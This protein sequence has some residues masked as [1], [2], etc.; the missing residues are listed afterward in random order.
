MRFIARTI[1]TIVGFFGAPFIYLIL[2]GSQRARVVVRCGDEV[3]LVRA[4]LAGSYWMLP[5][6]GVHRGEQPATA[7]VRELA[8]ETGVV[9]KEQQLIHHG[10][11]RSVRT[12][13]STYN[14]DLYSIGLPSKPE[15][16]LQIYEIS[17]AE[18]VS[19]DDVRRTHKLDKTTDGIFEVLASHR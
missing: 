19:F 3:L 6:G 2:A 8:E 5:G 14:Y 7:V 1:G 15:L 12:W 10:Q 9:V 13:G 4:W 16:K 11:H 17:D 18:W